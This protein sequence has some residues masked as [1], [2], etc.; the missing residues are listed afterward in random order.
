MN[1]K[2]CRIYLDLE[3]VYPEM[4]KELVLLYLMAGARSRGQ[5]IFTTHECNL[6]DLDILRKDEIWFTEKDEGGVSHIYSLSDFKPNYDK[7]I[8]KGYLAGQFTSIPFFTNP[9]ELKWYGDT[10]NNKE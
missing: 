5:L 9:K 7:D 4:T 10:E 2:D 6:L 8:R 3:Y 1:N